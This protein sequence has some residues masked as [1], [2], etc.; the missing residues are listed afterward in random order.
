MG[1]LFTNGSYPVIDESS[2]GSLRGLIQLMVASGRPVAAIL[3]SA[4]TGD[5]DSIRGRGYVKGD[6]FVHKILAGFGPGS[7]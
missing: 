4:P 5:F 3:D 6:I 7:S 1:D 2:C